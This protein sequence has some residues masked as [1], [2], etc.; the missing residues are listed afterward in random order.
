MRLHEAFPTI[1]A[2]QLPTY[3]G[4]ED[5]LR[6]SEVAITWSLRPK[7]FK[8]AHKLR[9]IHS[10]AAAVHQLM[11]PEL[12]NSDVLL[13]NA[14]EIHDPV[15]AEHVM[16]L[17]LAVAKGLPQ[18]VRLQ[19]K[20]LWGQGLMWHGRSRPQE[21]AGGNSDWSVWAALGEQSRDMPLTSA[22]E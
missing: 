17:I 22:C 7:Q 16:A 13:T 11:F 10:P 5:Y 18:A 12:V 3:D 6:E 21:L 20:H 15:V 8:I 9:W 14:R 4:I 1:E 19:Q 2:V